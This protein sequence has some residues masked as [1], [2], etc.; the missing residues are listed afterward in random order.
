MNCSEASVSTSVF[1]SVFDSYRD[2]ERQRQRQRDRQTE[3]VCVRVCELWKAKNCFY[4]CTAFCQEY[5]WLKSQTS[6]NADLNDDIEEN[7]SETK[8]EPNSHPTCPGVN[9]PKV[10]SYEQLHLGCQKS[11]SRLQQRSPR[12][13][14][15]NA[16]SL[17]LSRESKGENIVKAGVQ[18]KNGP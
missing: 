1:D 14:E 13:L 10:K 17:S 7:Q 3:S 4:L 15:R 6:E 11:N 2:G 5:E 18:P 9:N 12:Q 8:A 16:N